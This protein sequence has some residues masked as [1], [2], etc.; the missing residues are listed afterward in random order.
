MKN[1]LIPVILAFIVGY[2]LC[3]LYD[4]Y[5]QPLFRM[6]QLL[7][8]NDKW[9]TMVIEIQQK[10]DSIQKVNHVCELDMT[11]RQVHDERTWADIMLWEIDTLDMTRGE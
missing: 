11:A 2:A 1:K 10:F 4:H 7:R 6:N 5:A 3:H 8:E 9:Q